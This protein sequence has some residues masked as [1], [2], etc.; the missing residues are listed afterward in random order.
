MTKR[1]IKVTVEPRED[2]G[3]RIYSEDLPGLVLSGRERVKIM[4]D[5]GPA[6]RA[7]LEHKGE[8]TDV[9]I[10]ADFVMPANQ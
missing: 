7:I 2:G 3:I 6:V 9:I 8:S 5:I 10:D 4:G 1:H